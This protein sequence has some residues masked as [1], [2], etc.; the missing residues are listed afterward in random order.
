VEMAR[1]T[2]GRK[3]RVGDLAEV[4]LSLYG[5]VPLPNGDNSGRNLGRIPN[6]KWLVYVD[7]PNKMTGLATLNKARGLRD[8]H[9]GGWD[10]VIVLGWN[11]DPEIGQNIQGMNDLRLEVLVIPPDLLDQ[12]KKKGEKIKA[13]EI[14]FSSLQYLVLGPCTRRVVGDGEALE[15]ALANYVLLSPEALHLDEKGRAALQSYI[16]DDP[17]ALIEY[18][19]VDPD[20]DGQV[21]RSVWQ[22]YRG[23]TENDDDPYRV[24][25]RAVLEGLPRVEGARRVC[26]RT[27]DIF[28]WEAEAIVEVA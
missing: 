14:K 21:F 7:S 1:S 19:S 10:K 28:G 23:N 8:G 6:T 17:L 18:W 2:L 15:V 9:M 26:V 13:R 16:N 27:V 11:F 4:I 20:Y 25:P 24:V 22:D 5:A 12:M 3:Y